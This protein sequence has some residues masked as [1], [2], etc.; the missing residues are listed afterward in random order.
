MTRETEQWLNT[1]TLIGYTS[2]RGNAWHY[3]AS[4]QGAEPNHYPNAIPVEDV[5]RRLFDWLPIEAPLVA[6]YDIG[7]GNHTDYTVPKHKAILRSDTGDVVGVVGKDYQVHDYQDWL[8]RAV[9][10]ILQADELAIGS[11][12]LLRGGALAWVQVEME[13]TQ[14]VG[15]VEFRP[16]LTAATSL[17]GSMRTTYLTGSQLVVC[18][19]TLTAALVRADSEDAAFKVRHSARSLDRLSDVRD[20]LSIVEKAGQRF[21]TDVHSLLDQKIPETQWR[22]FADQWAGV[23][24]CKDS[25]NKLAIGKATK[26]TQRN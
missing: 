11:A 26:K 2:K 14:S 19:N 8:L 1:M 20:A 7:T 12:G 18:D 21:A 6:R 25:G 3:R 9:E 22:T 16:F 23:T 13:E 10:E 5:E 4:A 24:D 15:G 17:D